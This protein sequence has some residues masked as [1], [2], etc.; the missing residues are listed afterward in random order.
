[1]L[2]IL[3]RTIL[4][5]RSTYVTSS[6]GTPKNDWDECASGIDD[7]LFYRNLTYRGFSRQGI[8]SYAWTGEIKGLDSQH[9]NDTFYLKYSG[10]YMYSV[11]TCS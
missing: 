8:F 7:V 4:F 3:K 5:L 1:M 10:K 6:S 9:W 11:K 2:F